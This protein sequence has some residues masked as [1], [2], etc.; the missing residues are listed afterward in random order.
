MEHE[1]ITTLIAETELNYPH[2]K[3]ASYLSP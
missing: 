1:L 2:E 3:L